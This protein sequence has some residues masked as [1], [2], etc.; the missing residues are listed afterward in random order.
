MTGWLMV[1]T[2]LSAHAAMTPG[3]WAEEGGGALILQQT[4]FDVTVQAGLAVI[5]IDQRWYNPAD[6]PIDAVYAL[7][8]P[9][10]AAVRRM[11]MRC[12][13]RTLEGL[14]QT[15]DQ[16]RQTYDTALA[17]GRK[18][19]LLQ[20]ERANWFTQRVGGICPGEV[21]EV[22]VQLVT[23]PDYADQRYTL[24]LPTAI[25]ERFAAQ[26]LDVPEHI[27][28]T[29][30]PAVPGLGAAITIAEGLP[31]Q[32]LW[33]DTHDIDI[34]AEGVW[35]ASVSLL[36]GE[37]PDRDLVLSW[38]L[39]GTQPT[40]SALYAP[41]STRGEDG[42]VSI[43]V[44][45]PR[46]DE[47]AAPAP[48]ELIFVLD[49]SCSM[50]G[51]PWEQ[52]T[53][54]VARALEDMRPGDTF[55]LV[56]FSTASVPMFEQPQPASAENLQ[57]A[58]AWLDRFAGG[59]TE[60]EAGL[61]RALRLPGD[62]DALRLVLLLT[63]GY[64]GRETSVFETVRDERRGARVFA[65][66]VG[67]SVNHLLLDGV[68][69][70]GQG[71]SFVQ[72]L[73][74][75][76]EDAIARFQERIAVPAMT[77]VTVSFSRMKVS[78]V[79][80]AA[81]PDL[82]AG[83]PLRI[84]ART[85]GAPRGDVIVSGTVAGQP[86][87]I[88]VPIQTLSTHEAVPVVWAREQIA[89]REA[90]LAMPADLREE[91]ITALALEHHLVSR[92]TSLVAVADRPSR[93]TGPGT[94]EEIPHLAPAGT[95]LAGGSRRRMYYAP[96]SVDF[97]GVDITGALVRP[98]G[99]LLDRKRAMF[100]PLIRVRT[101][102]DAEISESVRALAG[103]PVRV[104]AVL[105]EAVT[106]RE[107]DLAVCMDGPL[108]AGTHGELSLRVRVEA[109]AVTAVRILDDGDALGLASCMRARALRWQLSEEITGSTTVYVSF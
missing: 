77:D 20:Q 107:D 106:E 68:A 103:A 56:K 31:V 86:H 11:E 65:M 48:R 51:K 61:R 17:E 23:T 60:M 75:D 109:G 59:G 38:S 71:D 29:V 98:Q 73:S 102:F 4:D 15:R 85:Q 28:G 18:A 97:E 39:A 46:V 80:P 92:Y 52:A 12:G 30:A 81:L 47:I 26:E 34:T 27:S 55:N 32:A 82:W 49:A 21:V 5:D 62:E 87:T 25:G 41:V 66:G 70:A 100:N 10:D 91:E 3:L 36:D 74:D 42:Y 57:A 24:T 84:V 6:A 53:A 54:A 43:Q 96:A 7:P 63:D 16:A 99:A 19:S 58:S 69:R 89:D 94:V 22:S 72:Q 9:V 88:R 14:I 76:A 8:L 45:P 104:E 37:R 79:A 90:D 105:W 93:C 64:I 95:R 78:L 101:D 40:A 83:K 1:A 50:S 13:G 67:S 108:V 33:S 35:G 44:E 2:A